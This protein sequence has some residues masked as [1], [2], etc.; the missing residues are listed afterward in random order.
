MSF[1]FTST[2]RPVSPS[3]STLQDRSGDPHRS[4]EAS[5][6]NRET[7]Q[8]NVFL[9]HE[10]EQFVTQTKRGSDAGT[11]RKT[12]EKNGRRV[13][14]N[15]LCGKHLTLA[16]QGFVSCHSYPGAKVSWTFADLQVVCL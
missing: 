4:A 2:L 6:S 1:F 14:Q 13:A 16:V 3:T 10:T 11:A 7:G 12:D 5:D 15:A 9:G 8:W